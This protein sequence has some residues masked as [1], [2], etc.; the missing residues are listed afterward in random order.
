MSEAILTRGGNVT[1]SYVNAQD[2]LKV[3]KIE[4]KT[5]SSNDYTD[6]AKAAVEALGTAST[7]DTG[8]DQGKIPVLV[9]NGKID[10]SLLPSIAITDTF[11][12]STEE[13]MLALDAQKGDICV[14]GD[15]SKTFILKQPPSKTK[16]NWIELASPADAVQS[17]NG[18]TG[19][20][21]LTTDD[22]NAVPDTRTVNAKP[23]SANVTLAASDIGAAVIS[24]YTAE[25][26][27][28]WAAGADGEY[29][30]TVNIERI[31]ETDTPSVDLVLSDTVSEAKEQIEAW[32]Y[33]GRITT[34]PGKI[35]AYCYDSAPTTPLNVQLICVR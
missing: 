17:V 12:A 9:E 35:T 13:E 33:V 27:T 16:E 8:T 21:T 18:K 10:S 31:L 34:G 25:L 15:L 24:K 20:V 6:E 4:G 22:L 7:Y 2:A 1:K 30:Q 26:G 5:L 32:S 14:R 29:V 23:L 19:V 28:S 11:T 3:D